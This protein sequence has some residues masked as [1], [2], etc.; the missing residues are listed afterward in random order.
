MTI[1]GCLNSLYVKCTP[2]AMVSNY[3]GIVDHQKAGKPDRSKLK[4]L[5][6]SVANFFTSL[7]LHDAF[8]WQDQRRFISYRRFVP[9]SFNDVRL[10]LN[11]AQVMSLIRNGPLD[12][13]T[14]DGDVTL[15]DDG[16]CLEPDNPVI[17]KIMRLMERGSKI[18]I[19]TA[20][21]Y[22]EAARYYERL[23]GLLQVIQTSDLPLEAKQNLIVMG[24][25]SNYCFKFDANSPDL[26]RLVPREE[27]LLKEM[28]LW[29]DDD[30]A[31]LLDIAE[32]S[33][34]DTVKNMRMEAI[35]VRKERAV[36]II[37]KD[38]QKFCR[39]TLEETVLIV[40]KILVQALEASV[41]VQLANMFRKC[42]TSGSDY[43]S[44]R[45]TV[46]HSPRCHGPC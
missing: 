14:F 16:M 29:T 21:G 33:L 43:P 46:C 28:M 12:L 27:W 41:F 32:D 1:V 30:I 2:F 31:E 45:S 26:L 35:V 10:V 11:T 25:E 22:T 18:G 20:A 38:G 24:G 34:R 19:V 5:V 40:Q 39:E 3:G 4:L 42:R 13:V 15:Y 37:P 7:A 9:P 36:G 17:T 8:I 6:P 44:A 23:F